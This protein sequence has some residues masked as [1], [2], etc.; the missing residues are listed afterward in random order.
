M[1]D[2]RFL[3]FQNFFRYDFARLSK[4]SCKDPSPSLVLL[5][6]R[7]ERAGEIPV[8]DNAASRFG[9]AVWRVERRGD[10]S[11]GQ[12]LA[13]VL[14]SVRRRRLCSFARHHLVC[15]MNDG[16]AT[17]GRFAVHLAE[18]VIRQLLILDS[19]H[20]YLRCNIIHCKQM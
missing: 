13:H 1:L 11:H 4:K 18:L 3:L 10:R 2:G 19:V 7:D 5:T 20:C 8:G 15:H 16:S 17:Q 12:R 6:V 9:R 14:L